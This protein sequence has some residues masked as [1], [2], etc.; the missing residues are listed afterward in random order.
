MIDLGDT[1]IVLVLAGGNALGAY[2]AGVCQA[3][4]EAGPLAATLESCIDFTRLNGGAAGYTAVAVD[5][6]SGAETAFDT[7]GRLIGAEHVRASAALPPAFPALAVDG[8]LYVDGGL[9]DNL[10]L[11]PALST[12]LERPMLCIAGGTLRIG[13]EDLRLLPELSE[14]AP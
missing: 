13:G 1:Q 5:L 12:P 14:N 6:E 3:L 10:P 4:Y 8:R 7:K 11:D 9:S 2:Q